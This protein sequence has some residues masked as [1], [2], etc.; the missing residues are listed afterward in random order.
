MA[1]KT[2]TYNIKKMKMSRDGKAR[3]YN[4][5][6][7]L[8]LREGPNGV[9]GTIY[10]HFLDGEYAVF[11]AE[12]TERPEQAADDGDAPAADAPTG[13]GIPF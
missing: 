4:E 10:F 5:V 9:S 13:D 6:G 1:I 2:T 11:P 8:F 12:K 3:F 7:R